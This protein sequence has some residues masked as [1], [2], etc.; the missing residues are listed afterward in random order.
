MGWLGHHEFGGTHKPFR[1]DASIRTQYETD[2]INYWLNI[3]IDTYQ[4]L[5]EN[6]LEDSIFIC[7]EELCTSPR[8]L[9]A[10]LNQRISH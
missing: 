2:N 7:F 5:L 6:A 4:Y 1:F 10:Y 8:L 3:W 9:V